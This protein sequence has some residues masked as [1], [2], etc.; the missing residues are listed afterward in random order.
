MVVLG[1]EHRASGMVVDGLR[2]ATLVSEAVPANLSPRPSASR[3]SSPM[4]TLYRYLLNAGTSF[5]FCFCL[6]MCVVG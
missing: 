1:F 6:L 3:P 4:L 2:F 5:L